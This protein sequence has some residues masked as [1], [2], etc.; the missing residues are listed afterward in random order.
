MRRLVCV[1]LTLILASS[2]CS[3]DPSSE[4]TDV[5]A[6]EIP[7]A[8]PAKANLTVI[9]V[10]VVDR[11]DRVRVDINGRRAIDAR[12]PASAGR[13]HPPI[14]EYRYAVPGGA[15]TV[16]VKTPGDT[17]VLR[18]LTATTPNW[19]VVQNQSDAVG[20]ALDLFQ[21]RPAFG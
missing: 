6:P 5:R 15:T 21:E 14:S 18:F 20:T 13:M 3:G 4:L 17:K 10:N 2:A 1:G 11:R 9:V 7:T 16:R 12:F 8:A 19:V